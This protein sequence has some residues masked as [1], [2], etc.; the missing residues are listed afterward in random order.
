MGHEWKTPL[1]TIRGYGQLLLEQ[2][3]GPLNPEQVQDVETILEAATHLMDLVDNL[4]HFNAAA[5]ETEVRRP[6]PV[7]LATLTRQAWNHLRPFTRAKQLEFACEVPQPL[8]VMGNPL[9]IRQVIIN[10]LGN[11]VKYTPAGRITVRGGHHQGTRPEVVWQVEDTGIGIDPAQQPHIFEP[12]HRGGG[13]R[14]G[15]EGLGLG[16]TVVRRFVEAHGGRI[17]VHSRPGEG[18]RFSVYWPA[19]AS[20]EVWDEHD[21]HLAGRGR[22]EFGA[23]VGE[24]PDGQGLP[25]GA[26]R[27]RPDDLAALSGSGTRPGPPRRADAGDGRLDGAE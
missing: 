18:S 23:P 20:E 11:A 25:G 21:A 1:H 26:G 4:L 16:L 14:P 10:L 17:E 9:Q 7:D 2:L 19:P 22:R 15:V 8:V 5:E 27:G 12:F 13:R 24:V 6:E 3:D